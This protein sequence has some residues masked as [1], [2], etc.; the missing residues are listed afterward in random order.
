MNAS[1]AFLPESSVA[2]HQIDIDKIFNMN[3]SKDDVPLYD[4]EIPNKK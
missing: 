1:N 2:D 4:H 3:K